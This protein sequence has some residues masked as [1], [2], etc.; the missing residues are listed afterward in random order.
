MAKV[1]WVSSGFQG[2]GSS[3]KCPVQR[4]TEQEVEGPAGKVKGASWDGVFVLGPRL[5]ITWD[6][7]DSHISPPHMG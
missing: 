3:E 2:E 7:L 6:S 4:E 1:R 5:G